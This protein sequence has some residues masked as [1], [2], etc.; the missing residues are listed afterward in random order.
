MK[1]IKQYWN[2]TARVLPVWTCGWLSRF[3]SGTTS[4]YL[5]SWWNILF[6]NCR[7]ACYWNKFALNWI[8]LPN[9]TKSFWKVA[10]NSVLLT[11]SLDLFCHPGDKT[12]IY[13]HKKHLQL[14]MCNLKLRLQLQ[15]VLEILQF[16]FLLSVRNRKSSK[17]GKRENLFFKG[18]P[19]SSTIQKDYLL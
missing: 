18:L 9:L 5:L 19:E 15:R 11:T 3:G 10:L 14:W 12:S 16:A 4:M 8:Y 6:Q 13:V 2:G 17:K 1:L 7:T